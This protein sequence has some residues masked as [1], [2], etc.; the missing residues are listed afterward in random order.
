MVAP[1]VIGAGITAA[2]SLA[3]GFLN[4]GAGVSKGFAGQLRAEQYAREDKFLQRRVADAKAA[5][6]HPLFGLGASPGGGG[7]S[8]FI[9][10]Q[11][12]TGSALGAGI[13]QAGRAVGR[14]F[15]GQARAKLVDAQIRSADASAARDTAQALSIDSARKRA[16]QDVLNVRPF[17]EGHEGV[18]IYP[19]G[20]NPAPPLVQRPLKVDPR[21]N[22]PEFIKL[23]GPKGT[24]PFHNP[25]LDV[26]VVKEVYYLWNKAKQYIGGEREREK[27]I[28]SLGAA[29]P[30]ATKAAKK[31]WA[32]KKARK[33]IKELKER[34]R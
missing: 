29:P 34:F 12:S 21:R 7:S 11:S 31:A 13:A 5:G 32:L 24:I 15:E 1:L 9:P 25:E 17:E 14:G 28:R 20:T 30:N 22:M 3:S 16:E 27:F 4:K 26:E 19:A 8:G 33:R 6:L 18:R 10:G 23:A 2:A